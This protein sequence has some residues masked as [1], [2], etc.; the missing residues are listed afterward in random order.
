MNENARRILGAICDEDRFPPAMLSQLE[1][2][3]DFSAELRKQIEQKAIEKRWGCVCR[4]IW[5][6]QRFPNPDLVPVLAKLLDD[7]ED[8]TYLEAVVDALVIMPEESAVGPLRRALFYQLPGDDLAFHFNRKIIAALS[9]VGSDAA[10]AGIREAL[11]SPEETIQ[12]SAAAALKAHS[13][14]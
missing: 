9:A 4:L 10:I 12:S 14:R 11:K 5:V 2:V 6:A 8:D 13:S 1:T 3:G 7:R